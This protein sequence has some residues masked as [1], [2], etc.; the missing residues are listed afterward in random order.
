MPIVTEVWTRNQGDHHLKIGVRLED[1]GVQIASYRQGPQG[2]VTHCP[3]GLTLEEWSTI[4]WKVREQQIK[5]KTYRQQP[6]GGT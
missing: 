5:N 4:T 2:G 6:K 1:D 3:F